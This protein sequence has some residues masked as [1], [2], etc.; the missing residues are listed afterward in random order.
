MKDK[1]C[2]LM[3]SNCSNKMIKIMN[4]YKTTILS[5]SNKILTTIIIYVL[6][7]VDKAI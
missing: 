4:K 7:K 2:M 1:I 5:I 6:I 3:M